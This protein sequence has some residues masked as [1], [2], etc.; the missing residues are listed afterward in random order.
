MVWITKSCLTVVLLEIRKRHSCRHLNYGF[1]QNHYSQQFLMSFLDLYYWQENI[2]KSNL[3]RTNS[4][5]PY[6][7]HAKGVTYNGSI[8]LQAQHNHVWIQTLQKRVQ[9]PQYQLFIEQLSLF[10]Y[11]LSVCKRLYNACKR[12][13]PVFNLLFGCRLCLFAY[14]LQ[15][16]ACKR[17]ANVQKTVEF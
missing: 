1:C 2:H 7:T 10:V 6:T 8:G 4:S 16:V 15:T 13:I 17:S 9:Y 14:C 5:G 11:C 12:T 3:A